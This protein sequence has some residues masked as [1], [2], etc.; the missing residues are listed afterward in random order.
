MVIG[1]LDF[2][3]T[4]GKIIVSKKVFA[5]EMLLREGVLKEFIASNTDGKIG[6]EIT[7]NEDGTVIIDFRF[8]DGKKLSDNPDTLCERLIE[9]YKD[10]ISGIIYYKGFYQTFTQTFYYEKD[11]SKN[12]N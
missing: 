4:G 3:L 2:Y 5:K 9:R 12:S 1:L 8:I 7:K 10:E 11:L 6:P